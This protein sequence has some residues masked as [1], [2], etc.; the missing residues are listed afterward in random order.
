MP[1]SNNTSNGD[2]TQSKFNSDN[3]EEI[4]TSD[5]QT[6]RF[7]HSHHY[8]DGDFVV[9]DAGG[10]AWGSDENSSNIF[11]VVTGWLGLNSCDD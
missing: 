10:V 9:R 2:G 7:P 3:G 4:R 6:D 11:T 8:P 5:G 1:W